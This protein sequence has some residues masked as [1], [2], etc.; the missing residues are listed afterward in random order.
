[1]ECLA[2][3]LK[4]KS[5]SRTVLICG[6]SVQDLGDRVSNLLNL[7]LAPFNTK[8]FNNGEL[9]PQVNE[10]VRGKHVYLIQSVCPPDVNGYLMELYLTLCMLRRASAKTVTAIIPHYGYARQDRKLL[11]H[12]PISA[13]DVA[14]M[15]VTSG[16]NRIVSFDLHC[17]QIQ[18]FFPPTVPCDN[19][20]AAVIAVEYFA[21]LASQWMGKNISVAVVSPDAGGTARAKKFM[22][23]LTR[24]LRSEHKAKGLGEDVKINFAMINKER[25]GAGLVDT[26]TLVGS[27]QKNIC[28][29]VDDMIDTAGTLCKAASV[30]KTQEGATDVYAFATHG[31][32]S[33]P[34]MNRINVS[35]LKKVVVC[36]TIPPPDNVCAKIEYLSVDRLLSGVITSII[37]CRS[38]SSFLE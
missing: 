6:R 21:S 9:L 33:G 16:V 32:F 37:N 36:D 30:L 13:S 28:I 34:A 22:D 8:V 17:G 35:C 19:I 14:G 23:L 3:Q 24:R 25:S 11:G 27:V 5:R 29:I 1:M 38:V 10:S 20:P 31:V 15:L 18:G 26:M 4:A 7:P 2:D 12:V